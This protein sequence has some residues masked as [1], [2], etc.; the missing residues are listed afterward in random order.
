MI[1]TVAELVILSGVAVCAADRG[2]VEG[3]L[4]SPRHLGRDREF[5]PQ[6]VHHP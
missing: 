3:S 1:S 6:G 4:V 2:A 5:Q